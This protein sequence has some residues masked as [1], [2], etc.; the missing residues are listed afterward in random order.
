MSPF[1]IWITV[2]KEIAINGW[3]LLKTTPLVECTNIYCNPGWTLWYSS[4]FPGTWDLYKDFSRFPQ[5]LISW[6]GITIKAKKKMQSVCGFLNNTA[7]HKQQIHISVFV[8]VSVCSF[9]YWTQF[10]YTF[11]TMNLRESIAT[12]SKWNLKKMYACIFPLLSL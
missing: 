11:V 2:G 7:I 1:K 12:K 3:S 10:T 8:C 9:H 4:I 5:S 6:Y